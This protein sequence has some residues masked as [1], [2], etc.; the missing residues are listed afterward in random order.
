MKRRNFLKA[1]GT[2]AF[3]ASALWNGS[4]RSK[5]NTRPNVILILVDDL[6]WKD[7]GYLNREAIYWHFPAY[8]KVIIRSAGRGAV[9]VFPD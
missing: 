1:L 6:G 9:P 4:C 3:T 7:T 8:P 5:E 2:S